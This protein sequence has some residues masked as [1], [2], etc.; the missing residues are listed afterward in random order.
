M[1]KTLMLRI[2]RL[3]TLLLTRPLYV[4]VSVHR[5]LL[6]LILSRKPAAA[7]TAPTV[8]LT[9]TK[10]T[11]ATSKSSLPLPMLR[12]RRATTRTLSSNSQALTADKWP[13]RESRQPDHNCI[14]FSPCTV[15]LQHSMIDMPHHTHESM[16]FS[17]CFT[18]EVGRGALPTIFGSSTDPNFI[19]RIPSI[20]PRILS[21]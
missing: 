13:E 20:W 1:P 10:A 3:R 14:M 19:W 7:P 8:A 15:P 17:V 6:V 16:Y 2:L 12:S 4:S 5:H 11:L 9:P 18:S 21:A